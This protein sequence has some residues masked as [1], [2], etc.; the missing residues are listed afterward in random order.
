MCCARLTGNA[1]PKKSPSGHHRTSLAISSQQARIES[2]IGK[3]LVKQQ[4]LP[5]K[6]VLTIWGNFGPLTGEIDSG[7]W[8]TAANFN[9]FLVLAALLHGTLGVSQPLRRW[10]D[11]ATYIPQGGH[12]VGHWPTFLVIIIMQT[13][14]NHGDD[15]LRSSGWRGSNYR[16][17]YSNDLSRRPCNTTH[18][19]ASVI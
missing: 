12:H 5:Y 13:S 2:T 14:A 10:T 9:G 19:C 3:K 16:L 8:S 15:W 18:N 4:Y 17:T 7:V 11:S 1:G 6:H